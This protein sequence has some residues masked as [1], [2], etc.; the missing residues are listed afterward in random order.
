MSAGRPFQR[1]MSTDVIDAIIINRSAAKAL[2]FSKPEEA[3]NQKIRTITEVHEEFA[4][5]LNIIGVTEDFNYY[6][7]KSKIQPV[8]MI[9]H[10]GYFKY[11]SLTLNPGNLKEILSFVKKKWTELFPGRPF[12]YYFLDD[13]INSQFRSEEQLGTVFGIFTG[14][15]IFIACL[16][17]FG[18]SAFMAEQRTKE[19]GIRKVLGSSVSSVVVLLTKEFTKWV[20]LANLFAWPIAYFFMNKW[21]QD[22]AYRTSVGFLV[23]LLSTFMALVLALLTVSFQ[24]IKVATANPVYSLRYE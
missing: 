8:M 3:V 2:G 4:D 11:I 12:E 7:L 23:F 22:F 6:A 17:L 9:L 10:S 19:I 1:D 18:L 14:L 5:E 21:L 13:H 16:G 15:G 24:T 20:L